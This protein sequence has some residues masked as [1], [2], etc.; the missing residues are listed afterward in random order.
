MGKTTRATLTEGC[1]ARKKIAFVHLG[2]VPIANITVS[3]V[4]KKVFCDYEVEE[5]DVLQRIKKDRVFIV[6]N[7]IVMVREYG[8]KLLM[9]YRRRWN[10]F[11]TTTYAFKYIKRLVAELIDE[12]Q[13]VFSFQMQSLFD[14]SKAGVP[15][16]VYTDHTYLANLNYAHYDK[17]NLPSEAWLALERR[18][19]QNAELV[20]VRS[21]HVRESLL[22]H[23]DRPHNSVECV[24]A[25]NN[26]SDADTRRFEQK[27]KNILFVGIDWD[28]KGGPE[29]ISAF[30]QVLVSHPDAELTIVGCT[31]EC[32][33]PQ[34]TVVGKVPVERIG[35][36]Y[37]EATLFCLPTKVESFGVAFVE[38]LHYGLPIVGSDVGAV[39]D[40]VSPARNGYLVPPGDVHALAEK[41]V[42]LLDHPEVC[43]RF[44]EQ[45]KIM[46]SER[47][48]W[49][50]VGGLFKQHIE[51]RFL[52]GTRNQVMI[53]T[54]PNVLASGV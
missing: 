48:N 49:N 6:I 28:R 7:T 24:Y 33:I 34:C 13:H 3:R 9:G 46:A 17:R 25:G 16:F 21:A 26:A 39:P 32:D 20:F 54:A 51:K 8:F 19:Y 42:Q 41:L 31:P 2:K 11:F 18:V 44:G 1:G 4:L 14:A 45:S 43:R 15:H 53:E 50:N 23:Y 12:D 22:T 35:Q 47:Y 40:M 10:C 29:L 5:I 38:A 30:R 27:K 52:L 36:Y 37:E